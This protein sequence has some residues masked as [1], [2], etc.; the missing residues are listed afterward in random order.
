VQLEKAAAATSFE[1]RPFGTEL[2]MCQ[3]YYQKSG[4]SNGA[5]W[6]PGSAT[7]AGSDLRNAP[8][9]ITTTDRATLSVPFLVPM[10]V[11]PSVTFYPGRADVTNTPSR[12]TVYN[13]STLVTFGASGVV[14][15]VNGINGRFESL[16]TST[17]LYTFNFVAEAEL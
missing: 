10:R 5:I 11:N 3:R 16:S 12:L 2:A 1:N 17:E 15:S 13:S 14:T 8:R 4:Q 6:I 9:F 7:N